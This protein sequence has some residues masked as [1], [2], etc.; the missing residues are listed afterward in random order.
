MLVTNF[1]KLR[2]RLNENFGGHYFY[3]SFF[4][5]SAQV[6]QLEIEGAIRKVSPLTRHHE[7]YY[8]HQYQIQ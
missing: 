7:T 6:E 8:A 3:P 5:A 4:Q 2:I 1:C